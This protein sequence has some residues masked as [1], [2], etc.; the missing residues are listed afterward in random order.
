MMSDERAD[1]EHHTQAE[2]AADDTEHH[3]VNDPP[4]QEGSPVVPQATRT[5]DEHGIMSHV[6][7]INPG[8]EPNTLTDANGKK[9][10]IGEDGRLTPF[11]GSIH[12]VVSYAAEDHP[13]GVRW[14]YMLTRPAF[15]QDHVRR[16]AG[17]M[18]WLLPHEVAAF[19]RLV[20]RALH[21]S[22]GVEPKNQLPEDPERHAE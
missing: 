18:V 17:Y 7:R 4:R 6:E 1:V 22:L 16:E 8:Q 2:A 9:W 21:P 11:V 13:D 10:L 3:P 20:D 14:P 5:D 19:H 15:T 12:H